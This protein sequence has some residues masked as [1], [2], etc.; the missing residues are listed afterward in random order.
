MIRHHRHWRGSGIGA[1]PSPLSISGNYFVREDGTLWFWVGLTSFLLLKRAL[2]GQ[3]DLVRAW[4]DWAVQTFGAEVVLRVFSQ[5]D[6]QGPPTNRGVESGFFARD[7]PDYDAVLHRLLTEASDR[8]ARVELV[9]HTFAD[10]SARQMADHLRRC[11]VIA[12]AHPNTVL[13][14]A[15]EPMVNGIPL[16]EVLALYTPRNL[17]TTGQYGADVYP[18]GR[19]LND[20]PPR[21]DE[22]ARKFK[23]AMEYFDGSGPERPF[24][25]PWKGP[26]VFDEPKRV[27]DASSPD[28][29]KAF[30]AGCKLFA[31]GV[32]MHGLFWAQKCDL[33]AITPDIRARIEA[34]VEGINTVP[35]QRYSGYWHPDDRGSLRRY[36][37]RGE[38]GRMYEISVRPFEFIPL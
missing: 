21:D 33:T 36:R 16:A 27:D 9:A 31:A 13:E 11:D 19:W 26:V 18:Q 23:G 24:S 6:W 17:W 15:N 22:F 10:G 32:T 5:V 37:R 25:P 4:I 2:N 14:L 20:H 38:D 8:G 12:L 30:G 7:Y 35:T 34:F 3:W 28:D 1:A 29:W